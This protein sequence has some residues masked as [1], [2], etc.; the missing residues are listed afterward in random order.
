MSVFRVEYNDSFDEHH[1]KIIY[2]SCHFRDIYSELI[3]LYHLK[4][5]RILSASEITDEEKAFLK[6]NI[7]HCIQKI[8]VRIFRD[9]KEQIVF[10]H[11]PS[12]E[13]Q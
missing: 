8:P 11:D 9:G 2:M 13:K 7:I 5:L 10:I 1:N 4:W 12:G 6:D 3:E